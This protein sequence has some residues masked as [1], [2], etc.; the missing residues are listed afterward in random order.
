MVVGL[1]GSYGHEGVQLGCWGR[2]VMEAFNFDSIKQQGEH[3]FFDEG[4]Q[5]INQQLEQVE[6]RFLAYHLLFGQKSILDHCHLV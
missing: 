2:M 5:L 1:L 6:Q 4:V 3:T